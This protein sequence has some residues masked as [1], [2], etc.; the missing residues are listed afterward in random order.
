MSVGHA[1]AAS[2][3]IDIVL[4]V[5]KRFGNLA[6]IKQCGLDAVWQ[7]ETRHEFPENGADG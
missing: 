7:W 6:R 2:T 3:Q 1:T 4:A 5:R